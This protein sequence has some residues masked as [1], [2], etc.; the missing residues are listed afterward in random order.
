MPIS[1]CLISSLKF[2]SLLKMI[3]LGY[4]VPKLHCNVHQLSSC[5]QIRRWLSLSALS[6]HHT[7]ISGA[8]LKCESRAVIHVLSNN[9]KP[10]KSK[11]LESHQDH[12]G[13][14]PEFAMRLKL[15]LST[16]C[17]VCTALHRISNGKLLLALTQQT[18]LLV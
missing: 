9:T 4:F 5:P 6:I 16:M 10:K 11:E 15:H 17:A 3:S 8:T 18:H 7:K 1:V 13:P 14:S 2:P 12:Q